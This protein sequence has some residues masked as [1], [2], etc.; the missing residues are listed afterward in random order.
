M[1]LDLPSSKK[2]VSLSGQVFSITTD[3]LL[4]LPDV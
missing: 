2:N 3:E 1:L 4:A